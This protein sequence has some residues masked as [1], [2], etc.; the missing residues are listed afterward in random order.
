LNQY[1]SK[2]IVPTYGFFFHGHSPEGDKLDWYGEKRFCMVQAKI[3]GLRLSQL[4]LDVPMLKRFIKEIATTLDQLE[5]TTYR[6]IHNN[7]CPKNIIIVQEDD[8]YHAIL[9]GFEKAS[10]TFFEGEIEHRIRSATFEVQYSNNIIIYSGVRDMICL[11]TYL[12][13]H[14]TPEVAEFGFNMTKKIH[15]CFWKDVDTPFDIT[16]EWLHEFYERRWIFL[17]L[18]ETEEELE[19]SKK[20]AVHKYNIEQFHAITYTWILIQ[21]YRI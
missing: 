14:P 11:F 18:L 16:K 17:T 20:E 10:Y 5:K 2:H 7:L 4:Q 3:N 8:E 12:S 13:C 9:V 19:D 21:L 6:L 1:Q 15:D